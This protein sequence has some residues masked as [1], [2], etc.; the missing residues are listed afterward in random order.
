M[1]EVTKAV[2]LAANTSTLVYTVPRGYE[3]VLSMLYVHNE[4]TSTK[5]VTATWHRNI[6]N[7][8]IKVFYALPL[9]AKQYIVADDG[10]RVLMSE[11]DTLT[12]LSEAGSTM[13]TICTFELVKKEGI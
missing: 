4:G 11:L 10:F 6:E 8:D 5:T 1:K 2:N 12:L 7:T 13:N 9:T 3:A